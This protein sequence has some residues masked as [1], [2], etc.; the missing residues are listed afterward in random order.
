MAHAAWSTAGMNLAVNTGTTLV[1]VGGVDS[2]SITAGQRQQ[3]DTTAL[4]DT[5]SRSVSGSPAPGQLT[6]SMFWDPGDT[7]HAYLLT[8]YNSAAVPKEKWQINCVDAGNATITFNGYMQEFGPLT[9][10]KNGAAKA[11][12][13]VAIDGTITIT[14]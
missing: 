3:I 6:F 5:A 12:M 11:S 4:A 1:N 8:S 13:T 7:S 14:P 10:E 2:L 9:F